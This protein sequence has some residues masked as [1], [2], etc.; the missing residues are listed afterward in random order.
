[1]S[2]QT[3]LEAI[4]FFHN[5]T[6]DGALDGE[7]EAQIYDQALESLYS[8]RDWEFLKKEDR[9]MSVSPT[10]Q[11]LPGDFVSPL[12]F[13]VDNAEVPFASLEHRMSV[14][15][16]IIIDFANRKFLADF[17][18][19]GITML[20]IFEPPVVGENSY[21]L[22]PVSQKIIPYYMCAIYYNV[23]FDDITLQGRIGDKHYAMFQSLKNGLE[24]WDNNI[25]SKIYNSNINRVYNQF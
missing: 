3:K 16:G 21:S 17:P 9:S 24:R 22:L 15:D 14:A 10:Y 12:K 2:K 25:K 19:G 20:Y 6:D 18:S 5:L 8:E 7:F 13:Y 11:S 23:D 1:M 4:E